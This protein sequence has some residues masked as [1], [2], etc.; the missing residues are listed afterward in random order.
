MFSYEFQ[1]LDFS[2][3]QAEMSVVLKSTSDDTL[4]AESYT[5]DRYGSITL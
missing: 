1:R 3:D 5:P 2:T 4:L